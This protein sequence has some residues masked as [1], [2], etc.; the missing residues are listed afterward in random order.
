ML[1]PIALGPRQIPVVTDPEA[2]QRKPD[3]TV[4][5]ALAHG[6][7]PEPAPLFK[8]LLAAL[9]TVGKDDAKKYT[10][11]VLASLPKATKKYL[12]ELMSVTGYRFHSEVFAEGK[13]SVVLAVL[14][15]R[16]VEIPE[17]VRAEISDCTDIDQLE[18]WGR[19]AATA[20][21]IEDLG[22]SAA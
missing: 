13:A 10:D 3:L 20:D 8:A 22:L 17:I 6:A 5:S 2:A 7:E 16:G 4:L 12:R 11:L 19:L 21:K 1:T 18:T 15:A 14:D 9:D